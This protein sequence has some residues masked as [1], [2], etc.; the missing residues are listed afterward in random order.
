MVNLLESGLLSSV[1]ASSKCARLR[2]RKPGEEVA[3]EEE[4]MLAA[5]PEVRDTAAQSFTPGAGIR[6]RTEGRVLFC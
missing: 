4:A 6:R 2:L 3:A 1:S 5:P